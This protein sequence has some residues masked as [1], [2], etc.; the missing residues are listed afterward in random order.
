[1]SGNVS[2]KKVHL[3]MRDGC[4]CSTISILLHLCGGAATV[5]YYAYACGLPCIYGAWCRPCRGGRIVAG[6]M[7]NAVVHSQ[8]WVVVT[9]TRG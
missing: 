5:A 1:M 7:T 2:R 8:P 9:D 6:A 3:I 4:W